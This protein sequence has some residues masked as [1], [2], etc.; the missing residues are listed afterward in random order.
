MPITGA[1]T[2]PQDGG[3]YLMSSRQ[4]TELQGLYHQVTDECGRSNIMRTKR[5]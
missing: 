4:E 5:H 1:V 2:K 3:G